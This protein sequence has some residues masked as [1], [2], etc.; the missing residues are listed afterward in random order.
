MQH[1][2]KIADKV[3]G[4]ILSS[5]ALGIH[6][7]IPYFFQKCA[8]LLSRLTPSFPLELI[9]WNESLK[10]LRWLKAHLPSWTSEL[11]SNPSAT[12]Q[13][14]PRWITELLRH[15]ARAF[16]EVNQFHVPTLCL[17]GLHDSVA[18]SDYIEQFMKAIPSSDKQSV[19]FADGGHC[20]LNEHR[21]D[22]AVE[23]IFQWLSSRL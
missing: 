6:I 1:F 15:E 10:K 23:S 13:Y 7:R 11:L 20:P 19:L 5:P 8:Q 16:T 14:T 12:I 17:Y 4:V 3:A 21:K 9:R 18:D 22:E 2:T